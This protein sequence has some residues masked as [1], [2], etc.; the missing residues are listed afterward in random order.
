MKA[1]EMCQHALDVNVKIVL[2]WIRNNAEYGNNSFI[3]N[4]NWDRQNKI[5]EYPGVIKKLKNLGYKIEVDNK[6]IFKEKDLYIDVIK[7]KW[8]GLKAYTIKERKTEL[9]KLTIKS[10]IISWC[11]K[12]KDAK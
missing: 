8:F 9:E 1:K 2:S 7:K 10:Y 6:E 4:D 12:E 3:V 5:I 11:C